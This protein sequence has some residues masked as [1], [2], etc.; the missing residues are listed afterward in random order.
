[1][2]SKKVNT[3]TGKIT[4]QKQ[5]AALEVNKIKN[6]SGTPGTVNSVK[7]NNPKLNKVKS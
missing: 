5:D 3:V 7:K 2:S 4:S 1:M 6:A